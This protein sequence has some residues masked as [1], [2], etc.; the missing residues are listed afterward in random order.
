MVDMAWSEICS[1]P[2]DDIVVLNAF[3]AKVRERLPGWQISYIPSMLQGGILSAT[4]HLSDYEV[5]CGVP[6][7]VLDQDHLKPLADLI[8]RCRASEPT[9]FIWDMRV[10][11]LRAA[12]FWT[13]HAASWNEVVKGGSGISPIDKDGTFYIRFDGPK[14]AKDGHLGA[15]FGQQSNKLLIIPVVKLEGDGLPSSIDQFL[16]VSQYITP[17]WAALPLFYVDR[18]SHVFPLS[19]DALISAD[20]DTYGFRESMCQRSID[21]ADRGVLADWLEENGGNEEFAKTLRDENAPWDAWAR[22]VKPQQQMRRSHTLK[23]GPIEGR[24]TSWHKDMV[25]VGHAF[26]EWP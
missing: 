18:P 23:K 1:S 4:L 12:Q 5:R 21:P 25:D 2:L 7:S 6:L 19:L 22:I 20:K 16:N 24:W 11:M 9:Y 26:M 8:D 14:S 15:V 17:N 3:A 13:K 10:P